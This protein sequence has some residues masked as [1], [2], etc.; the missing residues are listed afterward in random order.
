MNERF[1]QIA[2]NTVGDYSKND[3]WPFFTE[4]L[5]KFA[6]SIVKECVGQIKVCAQQIR[7]DD[8]YSEDNFWPLFAGIVDDVAKDVQTHFGV[9]E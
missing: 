2:V 6:E 3:Y 7:D 9:E 4:E 1:K 8:G 5:E